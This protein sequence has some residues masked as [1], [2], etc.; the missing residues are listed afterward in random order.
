[1]PSAPTSPATTP[2][3]RRPWVAPLGVLTVAFLAFTLPPYLGLDPSE[4]R[5]PPRFPG[6]YALLV[7]HIFFGSVA[8]L[9][10]C[11]QVWPWLRKNHPAVHRWS[12]RLYVFAGVLPAG[13]ATLTFTWRGSFGPNQEVANTTLAVLWLAVTVAGYRTAR[14]RRFSEHR[15]WMIRSFALAFSIVTNRLWQVV[16]I[17]AFAPDGDPSS[18]QFAQAIGVS[19]WVSWLANLFLAEWWLRRTDRKRGPRNRSRQPVPRASTDT[20]ART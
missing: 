6:H 17:L 14:A 10:G 12:G 15:E 5:I 20:L 3:L 13:L 11:L 9:T 19:T 8:L 2:L 1:M 7:L 4:S 16:F 18:A